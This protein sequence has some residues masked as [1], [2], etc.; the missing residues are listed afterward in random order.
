MN[1]Q[2]L[3]FEDWFL[4]QSVN[5]QNSFWQFEDIFVYIRWMINT[6]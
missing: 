1:I 6:H 2:F 4:E 3:K 5:N